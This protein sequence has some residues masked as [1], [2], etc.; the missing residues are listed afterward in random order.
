M[1]KSGVCEHVT[2]NEQLNTV[3]YVAAFKSIV[4]QP[5]Q[6]SVINIKDRRDLQETCVLNTVGAVVCD[7]GNKLAAS[8][9]NLKRGNFD[10]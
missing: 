2:V 5:W 9:S 1:G 10:F 3:L 6:F 4:A 8:S 7:H